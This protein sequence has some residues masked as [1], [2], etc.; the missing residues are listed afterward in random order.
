MITHKPGSLTL[1]EKAI[2]NRHP[3]IG[4]DILRKMKGLQKLVPIVR[5]HHEHWDGSGYPA[6]FAGEEIPL[7]ARIL[8]LADTMDAMFSER[9]YHPPR[10]FD[11]VNAEILRC[12]GTQ[13]D[14]GVVAAY[15]KMTEK[16]DRSFFKNSAAAINANLLINN[17]ITGNTSVRM[18]KKS[19]FV[20]AELKS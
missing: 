12:S 7:G 9:P 17:M 2:M 10:S 15:T 19:S 8:A 11:E 13:F 5:H 6:G 14:P 3:V 18:I 1:E 20:G 16:V 4:A